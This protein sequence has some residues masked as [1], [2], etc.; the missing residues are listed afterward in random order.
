MRYLVS[1][2]VQLEFC[3]ASG[4]LP[5]RKEV[6]QDPTF[7]ADPYFNVLL[8]ALQNG[9]V[10]IIFPLW[11]MVEDKLSNSFAQVWS[12]VAAHP[13]Y[14]LEAVLTRHLEGLARRLDFTLGS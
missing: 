10:P 9:R 12:E 4:L 13:R 14:R 8:D 2:E 5:V 3:P 6:L 11:G 1:P 7:T